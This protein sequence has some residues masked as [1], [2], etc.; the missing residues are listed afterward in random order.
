LSTTNPTW[1]DPGANPGLR[2]EMPATDDLSELVQKVLYQ[3]LITNTNTNLY[4][5]K[6]FEIRESRQFIKDESS[7]YYDH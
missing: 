6:R 4:T 3:H 7:Q 1:I 5:E 2:G